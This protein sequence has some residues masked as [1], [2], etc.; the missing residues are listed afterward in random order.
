MREWGLWTVLC[1]ALLFGAC[2]CA[3]QRE[4]AIGTGVTIDGRIVRLEAQLWE[5]SGSGFF[6]PAMQWLVDWGDGTFSNED[7]ATPIP[8]WNN[9]LSFVYWVHA[10]AQTGSYVILVTSVNARP[11][12]EL[13]EISE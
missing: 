3:L 12:T 1:L 13:V 4:Y 5:Y 6:A 9:P 7:T 2:G 11:A 8:G 10:Y